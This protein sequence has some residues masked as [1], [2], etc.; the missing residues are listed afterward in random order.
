MK[1]DT[2]LMAADLRDVGRYAATAERLG[3][4][5]IWTAEAGHD[6]YLR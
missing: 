2:A 6:P 5:G 1:I 4:D 3:Y